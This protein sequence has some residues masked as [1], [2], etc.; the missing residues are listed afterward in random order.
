MR[1]DDLT[2]A[3]RA[4]TARPLARRDAVRV[5]PARARRRRGP[6]R[7]LDL[8]RRRDRGRGAPAHERPCGL[9]ARLVAR[10]HDARVPSRGRRP[11]ADLADVGRRRRAGAADDVAARRR[12]PRLEPRR[13]AH[14]VLGGDRSHARSGS[15]D[16]HRSPGL[17]G[18]RSGLP[19]HHPQAPLHL[20]PRDEG[21]KAGDPRRLACRR[22]GMVTRRRKARVCRRDRGRRGPAPPRAALDRR[23]VVADRRAATRRSSPKGS[24]APCRGQ[25]TAPHCSPSVSPGR[26]SVTLRCCASRST[27]ESRPTSRRRSTATSCRVA[28]AIPEVSRSTRATA[29]VLFCVRDRGCTHLYAVDEAGGDPRLLVGGTARIVSALSVAGGTAA[30]VLVT[31]TSF[32]EVVVVDLASGAETVRTEHGKSAAELDLF[33]RED[34]E[35][36]ISDGTVVHGWLIRDPDAATPS[37]LLLDIHGG[38]HNAWNG[39]ADDW[40]LYHQELAA[41]GWTVLLLNPRGSDGYGSDFYTGG[42]GAWGEADA[43]DFLEPID[44]L[45]AEGIADPKRLA[46]T[47]YSYG[48]FMTCY[49]TSRDNRFAAA[50]AGGVVSDLVSMAGT[51]DI[52][53]LPEPARA[54]RTV[55]ERSRP[56]RADVAARACRRRRHADARLPRRRR[57]ALPGRAGSRVARRAARAR[58]PDPPRPLPRCFASVRDRRTPVASGRLEP[59]RRRLGR[60]VR[61]RRTPGDR[62]RALAAAPRPAGCAPRRSRRRA[63][64]HAHTARARRRARRARRRDC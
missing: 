51:S 60:A 11:A 4:R 31:A 48:G 52:G 57:R 28:R 50:V 35:F 18:R 7:S 6:F 54:R 32:G 29:R 10:R 3:R 44:Q 24:P 53:P 13:L 9:V 17:P 59:P 23:R 39:A 33:V 20:R 63:R 61:G 42:I 15:A 49:L 12:R 25:P 19:A 14:R 34:R 56:V 40:H 5:R 38:P 41:R 46:V 30:I 8:V 58:R 2:D 37:P 27:A 43:K 62:R 22:S 55:V 64:D 16:R 26:R 1:I 47:G 36:T 45:V 21:V